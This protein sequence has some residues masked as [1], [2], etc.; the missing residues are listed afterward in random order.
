[1][2]IK[3]SRT[4]IKLDN[5]GFIAFPNMPGWVDPK[6]KDHGLGPLAMVVRS[7]LLPGRLIAMHEHQNDEIVS[8]VPDGI[9]R[10]D[11]RANGKLVVDQNHLMVMNAGR[12]F[13]HSE[14]TLPTDSALDMLQILIRPHE[15][16][17]EPNIQH[18]PI[19]A[20]PPNVWRHLFGPEGGNAPFFV[21]NEVDFF[22]IRLDAGTRLDFPALPARD[23]YFYV[24]SGAIIAGGQRFAE[25][26][27]GLLRG[28]G[29]L[30]LETSVAGITVAFLVN[31]N[32]RVTRKGTVGDNRKIPP[33]IVFRGLQLW[34]RLQ[35]GWQRPSDTLPR[36]TLHK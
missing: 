10:H 29:Q 15:V 2:L 1:M 30:S 31:S 23:L 27:Q 18:G 32:A 9:M 5:G 17:L 12:S 22:D 34:K 11:D 19:A 25:A 21:R 4:P 36:A 6:S 33:G 7:I 35:Q 14:E 8:W 16:D 20:S 13:W 24:F 3:G 26:E 28:G